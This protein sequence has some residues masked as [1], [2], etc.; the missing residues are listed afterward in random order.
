MKLLL[1]K[2]HAM[3]WC[4]DFNGGFEMPLLVKLAINIRIL[5]VCLLG[6]TTVAIFSSEVRASDATQ[7]FMLLME[8]AHRNARA[9]LGPD[10]FRGNEIG[11]SLG[12]QGQGVHVIPG[13]R[14]AVY[15]HDAFA[16]GD[17]TLGHVHPGFNFTAGSY[18][19]S[20]VMHGWEGRLKTPGPL[21]F[22]GSDIHFSSRNGAFALYTTGSLVRGPNGWSIVPLTEGANPM[23]FVVEPMANGIFAVVPMDGLRPLTSETVYLALDEETALYRSY[24]EVYDPHIGFWRQNVGGK[25]RGHVLSALPGV[26]GALVGATG[27]PL[28]GTA[29]AGAGAVGMGAVGGYMQYE[30]NYMRHGSFKVSPSQSALLGAYSGLFGFA[31]GMVGGM[32][33]S[34]AARYFG[35]DEGLTE[36]AGHVGGGIGGY[37]SLGVANMLFVGDTA[38]AA[39]GGIAA[40]VAIAGAVGGIMGSASYHYTPVGGLADSIVAGIAEGTGMVPSGTYATMRAADPNFWRRGDSRR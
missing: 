14:A 13:A 38:A 40:P 39:F 26:I 11:V 22:S 36:I 28:I 19:L 30:N 3:S 9:P 8:Q 33:A 4:V 7:A 27:S 37:L 32:A 21:Q 15:W 29:I 1:Q 35:A 18:Q 17:I 25:F 23:G 2:F 34:R 24:M 20:D 12:R 6:A 5:V 16:R 10:G 31:G